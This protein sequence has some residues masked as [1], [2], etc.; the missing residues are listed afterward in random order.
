MDIHRLRSNSMGYRL[1]RSALKPLLNIAGLE[2]FEAFRR[3][4]KIGPLYRF[5]TGPNPQVHDQSVLFVNTVAYL[6]RKHVPKA[7]KNKNRA[8]T[9]IC[10]QK[11]DNIE[12]DARI[13]LSKEEV[14]QRI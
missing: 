3:R 11:S 2:Q 7:M 13:E 5:R 8:D 9:H 12:L 6:L 14:T 10:C 4:N 1:Y